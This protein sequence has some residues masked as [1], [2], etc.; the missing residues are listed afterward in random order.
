MT[1]F[2]QDNTQGY[3]AADLTELNSAWEQ[4]T[5]H[6]GYALEDGDDAS[7]SMLDNWS[8]T[9]L[10]EYDS[11]KRGESLVAWFYAA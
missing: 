6:G 7:K 1:R 4:I 8:E 9:L 3:D 10:S 2:R 5:S 11:G